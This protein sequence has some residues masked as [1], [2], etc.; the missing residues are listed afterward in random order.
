MNIEKPQLLSDPLLRALFPQLSPGSS[1]T[2]A[3]P[4]VIIR[5]L[6]FSGED[7]LTGLGEINF[8]FDLAKSLRVSSTFDIAEEAGT[9]L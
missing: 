4:Y 8:F 9:W 5:E 6:S 3:C 1:Q 7:S 2:E